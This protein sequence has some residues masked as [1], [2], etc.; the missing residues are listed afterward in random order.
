MYAPTTK[1][2]LAKAYAPDLT[3][4]AALNRLSK[5]ITTCKP[6]MKALKRTGYSETQK[7]ISGKQKWLIYRYLGVP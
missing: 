6:L 1:Q 3:P 2:E 7:K 4:K 5:W